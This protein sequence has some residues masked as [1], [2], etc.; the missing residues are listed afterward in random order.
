MRTMSPE[1]ITRAPSI[2]PWELYGTED[3]CFIPQWATHPRLYHGRA[4]FPAINIP[5]FSFMDNDDLCIG[6]FKIEFE[7]CDHATIQAPEDMRN[8]GTLMGRNWLAST[9]IKLYL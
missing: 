1:S 5:S 8:L 6:C 2:D 7:A 4:F 3:G 9:P